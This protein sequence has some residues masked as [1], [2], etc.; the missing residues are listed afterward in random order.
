MTT[1]TMLD[2][3]KTISHIDRLRVLGVLAIQPSSMDEISKAIELPI[4]QIFTHIEMLA[5]EGIIRLVDFRWQID[6]KHLENMSR[7]NLSGLN[8]DV[9]SPDED[10]EPNIK[11]ILT[12]FLNPDGSIRQLPSEPGKLIVILEY[13]LQAFD[14]GVMYS[15]MEVN[16]IIK[17]FHTDSAGLRRDMIDR[18]LLQRKSDGSQY[19]RSK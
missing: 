4:R 8:R 5:H 2:F 9:F 16:K 7:E 10:A 14:P 17:K 13:L 12:N 19:W 15:E 11:K 3:I 6:N 18:S 1:N